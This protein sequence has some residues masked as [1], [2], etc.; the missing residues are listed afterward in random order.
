MLSEKAK[1]H[2]LLDASARIGEVFNG[3][4]ILGH[5]DKGQMWWKG[6]DS[7]SARG[8]LERMLSKVKRHEEMFDQREE[9]ESDGASF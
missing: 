3:Y 4:V 9:E 1:E 7:I 5:D 6:R 8:M 2:A